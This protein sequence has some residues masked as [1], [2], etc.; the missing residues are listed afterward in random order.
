MQKKNSWL[1]GVLFSRSL[2]SVFS[3][4]C[5]TSFGDYTRTQQMISQT[6]QISSSF[7]YLLI[8]PVSCTEIKALN[9]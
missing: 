5:I 9:P 3:V 7:I 4:L 1:A 8:T 2:F 6:V